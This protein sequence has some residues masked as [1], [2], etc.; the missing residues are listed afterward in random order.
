MRWDSEC[1]RRRVKV[2]RPRRRAKPEANLVEVG[3]KGLLAVWMDEV[4][5]F[6]G[7]I[8]YDEVPNR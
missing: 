2:K 7:G 4:S 5:G 1:R 3:D 8:K 6:K